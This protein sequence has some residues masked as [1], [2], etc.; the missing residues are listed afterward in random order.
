[1]FAE[2]G[3][4]VD[5]AELA[6]E[7][8]R[9]L[10]R[11]HA[12]MP[13][14]APSAGLASAAHQLRRTA[15]LRRAAGEP[16][17]AHAG[18]GAAWTVR[19]EPPADLDAMRPGRPVRVHPIADARDLPALLAPVARHLQTVGVAGFGRR[20]ED[21]AELLSEAGATRICP[22]KDVAFP[23]PWWHHDGRGPLEALLRLVDLEGD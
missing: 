12:A 22:L 2:A 20:L 7:L 1:V 9:A 4:E 10:A 15:E 18:P 16:V 8:A 19:L 21:V 13:P 5:A 14:T 3:G 17:A 6:E 23:P 11:F